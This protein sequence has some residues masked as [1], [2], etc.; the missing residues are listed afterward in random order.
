[1]LRA[2]GF[3]AVA[4]IATAAHAQP[5]R[6][7]GC[8]PS[9]TRTTYAVCVVDEHGAPVANAEVRGRRSVMSEGFGGVVAGDEDIGSAR[10]DAAGRAEFTVPP[11]ERNLLV[12]NKDVG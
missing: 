4:S 7:P 1:M 5:A 6:S 10:T 12:S 9:S 2:L 8:V 3:V 11:L